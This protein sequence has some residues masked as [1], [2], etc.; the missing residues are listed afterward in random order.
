MYTKYTY[1]EDLPFLC[2]KMSQD[3]LYCLFFVTF[4]PRAFKKTK[5]KS[6]V[7]KKTQMA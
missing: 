4:Q 6:I 1:K 5:W 3:V 7:T 2:N